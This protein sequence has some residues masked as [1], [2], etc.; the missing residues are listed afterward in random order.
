MMTFV[1]I[2]MTSESPTNLISTLDYESLQ[3]MPSSRETPLID[4]LIKND[5]YYSEE[6]ETEACP[7]PKKLP[8]R[9]LENCKNNQLP[10]SYE[11]KCWMKCYKEASSYVTDDIR[12]EDVFC[13]T[14]K[15]NEECELAYWNIRCRSTEVAVAV[16]E[17]CL[18][19]FD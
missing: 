18:H 13:L 4:V 6:Q 3:M 10:E 14:Q 17:I 15:P 9:D 7:N 2:R 11:A 5:N 1:S 8:L 12:T 16:Y 19:I